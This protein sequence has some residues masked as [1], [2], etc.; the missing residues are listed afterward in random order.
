MLKVVKI[1]RDL[2]GCQNRDLH[3][4]SFSL[5]VSSSIEPKISSRFCCLSGSENA[6][7][8]EC[9]HQWNDE[10]IHGQNP[11]A[12]SSFPLTFALTRSTVSVVESNPDIFF[13]A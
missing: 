4:E 12:E 2:R 13:R 7:F 10:I 1:D 3:F 6:F 11:V 8:F 9:I 5:I